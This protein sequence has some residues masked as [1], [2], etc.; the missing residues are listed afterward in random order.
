MSEEN[1]ER[2]R[3]AWQAFNFG[4]LDE[5][6]DGATSG[7]DVE[8]RPAFLYTFRGPAVVRVDA[9]LTASKPSKPLG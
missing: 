6:L 8:L 1:V 5:F 4:N 9:F 2:V 7:V 3:R